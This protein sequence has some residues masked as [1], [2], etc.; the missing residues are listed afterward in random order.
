MIEIGTHIN[1]DDSAICDRRNVNTDVYGRVSATASEE[2]EY[3]LCFKTN[4]TKAFWAS[5]HIRLNFDI[6]VG[7]DAVDFEQLAKSEHLSCTWIA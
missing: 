7:E 1:A 2:G 5:R 6:Q 3:S 4:R